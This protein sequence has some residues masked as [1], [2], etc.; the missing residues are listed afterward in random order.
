MANLYDILFSEV[1]LV[2]TV[3]LIVL[4]LYW[5]VSMIGGI[6][7]DLD[8]D[9]EVDLDPA[10][11]AGTALDG[12]NMDFQD[13]S[14]AE[15]NQ[16]DVVGKRRRPLK[17]WQVFLIYFNFVGLPF[18]FT[19]TCW[20]FIWWFMTALTTAV[21]FSYDNY[22]GFAIMLIAMFPALVVNKIFTTPFKGFF[23][24]LNKN[25]D[26]PVD[27]LGRQGLLLSSISGDKL[28]NAEVKVDGNTLSVY[29]KSLSGDPLPY[30]S[31]ILIIKRSPD[32][33]YYLVESYN[34]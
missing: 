3:L 18:M 27:Y 31:S 19:F 17:W 7:F 24:N 1:N 6:D 14:N 30:G 20:I 26:A 5:L 23:K 11:D 4:L 34:E 16:E 8:F 2:L 15:V 21:T 29:V 33:S 28:G 22:F 13:L 12:G 25:G 10:I 32:Q 9:V